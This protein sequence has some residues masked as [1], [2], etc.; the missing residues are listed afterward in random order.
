MS[1]SMAW[2]G[3][4]EVG[5]RRRKCIVHVIEGEQWIVD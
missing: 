2:G 5:N 3:D 1:M 4:V